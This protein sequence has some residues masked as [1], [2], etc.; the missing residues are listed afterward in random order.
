MVKLSIR[1]RI[2]DA[3]WAL[4]PLFVTKMV[5]ITALTFNQGGEENSKKTIVTVCTTITRT[6]DR[7]RVKNGI[8]LTTNPTEHTAGCWMIVDDESNGTQG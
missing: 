2:R 1:C 4:A 6:M 3:T 5:V 7:L 8:L